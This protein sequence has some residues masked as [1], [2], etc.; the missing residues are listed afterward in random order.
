MPSSLGNRIA[1]AL[2]RRESQQALVLLLNQQSPA[3]T[4]RLATPFPEAD[5]IVVLNL[6][7]PA[8]IPSTRL[9][10]S[11][12]FLMLS[13][14]IFGIQQICLVLRRISDIGIAEPMYSLWTKARCHGLCA[15]HYVNRVPSIQDN[16]DLQMR[17]NPSSDRTLED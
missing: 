1:R 6:L 4:N 9:S 16:R 15:V 8:G 11:Q 13:R 14:D 5:P 10:T 17:A 3:R 12:F 7:Q 2:G